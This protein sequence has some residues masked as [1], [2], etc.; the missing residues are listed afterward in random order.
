MGRK[1]RKI[2]NFLSNCLYHKVENPKANPQ[3]DVRAK[4]SKSKLYPFINEDMKL[5]GGRILGLLELRVQ[6][7]GSD[8]G[9]K[10]GS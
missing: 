1:N 6:F 10:L 8:C 3:A 2:F 7:E 9:I 5:V 4:I